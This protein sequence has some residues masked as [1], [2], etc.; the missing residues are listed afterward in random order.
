MFCGKGGGKKKLF[1]FCRFFE[2]LGQEQRRYGCGAGSCAQECAQGL[3][4]RPL[5]TLLSFGGGRAHDNREPVSHARTLA[6]TLKYR[7]TCTVC[8][9]AHMCSRCF[10]RHPKS[11][12]LMLF[13]E[14]HEGHTHAYTPV[15]TQAVIPATEADVR[16]W[17]VKRVLKKVGSD[18]L[19]EWEGRWKNS[20]VPIKGN[21][22]LL[23]LIG[24]GTGP[25]SDSDDVDDV[26]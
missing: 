5:W 16:S 19:V 6:H 11:H 9:D 22:H 24:I 1:T 2:I 14:V 13:R 12:A 17:P 23:P 8:A 15:H 10:V 7:Y 3:R 26:E 20:K 4:V 21:E 18:L 25:A